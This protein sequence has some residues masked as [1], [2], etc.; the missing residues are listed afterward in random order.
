VA[1]HNELGKIGEE[2]ACKFLVKQDFHVVCRNYRKKWGEIDII[3][4]KQGII[5][6]IE[7]KSVSRENLGEVRQEN[8]NFRPE[9]NLHPQ[10]IKRLS[11]IIQT[12]LLE[13]GVSDETEWQFDVICV[14]ISLTKRVGRVKYLEDIVL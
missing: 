7:V 10:K 11:R 9:D 4:E 8:D 1:K 12:Y 2:I 5:H 6:F 3:T 13:M 14:Y